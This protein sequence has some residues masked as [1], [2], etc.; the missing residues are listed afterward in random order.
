MKDTLRI[1]IHNNCNLSCSYCCNKISE[2]IERMVHKPLSEIDFSLYQNICI[3]GGEPLLDL[4]Y[5]ES[6]LIEL[7]KDKIIILYT[8]GYLLNSK[9]LLLLYSYN[10]KFIT[11]GIHDV[12]IPLINRITH[13]YEIFNR[14]YHDSIQIRFNINDVH[15]EAK[16]ELG[17]EYFKYLEQQNKH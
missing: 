16:K 2:Q 10:I 15:K 14:I 6:I 5:L 3:T 9:A 11:V 7:P 4:I 12:I 8:N 17:E 1:L 13:E